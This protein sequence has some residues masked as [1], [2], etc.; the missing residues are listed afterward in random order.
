MDLSPGQGSI[1]AAFELVVFDMDGVLVDSEIIACRCLL[2][3][4]GRHGVTVDLEEVYAKFLGRSFSVVA[5]DYVHRTGSPLPDGFVAEL[6]AR[7]TERYHSSLR[8]MPDAARLL[9]GLRARCCIASSSTPD[10]IRLSLSLTALASFFGDRIFDA[11]MVERGKPA[12]DLFLLAAERM[13]ARPERTLVIEDSVS[14]VVAGKAAG[15]TVWGFIGGGHYTGRDAGG[16]L[17]DAGADRIVETMA[18]LLPHLSE[19]VP[20]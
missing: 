12:P 7:L 2:E 4:L 19:V 15:M 14:G 17:A 10:R 16:M 11:T 5:Q 8:A 18:D 6:G 20:P 3:T 13:R 9:R 1:V